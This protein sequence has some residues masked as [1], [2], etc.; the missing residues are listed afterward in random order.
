MSR[1]ER[2]TIDRGAGAPQ[3]L[4]TLAGQVAPLTLAAERTLPL[5]PTVAPLLPSG[6]RR[7]STVVVTSAPSRPQ[8]ALSLALALAARA[9]ASGSWCAAVGVPDLGLLAAAELGIDLDRMALVP[10][11][12][13]AH[14]VS[15]VAAL[16]DSVDILL[17]RPPAHLK[18]GDARRLTT[19]TR[20]RGVVLIPMLPGGSR[21]GPWAEGADVRLEVTEARWAGPGTGEGHLHGRRIVV[22]A[23]GRGAAARERVVGLELPAFEENVAFAGS[24][25]DLIPDRTGG[26]DQGGRAGRAD[27]AERSLEAG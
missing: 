1:A 20:E 17:A 25:A 27:R 10:D 2:I 11:V 16:I 4:R 8:G 9:A 7:G 21:G 13:P 22:T 6:L 23:G 24:D 14:W 19:R 3:R 5:S 18:P 12:P 26:A 15:V